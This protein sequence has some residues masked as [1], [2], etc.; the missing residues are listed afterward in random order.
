[1][2]TSINTYCS[3]DSF[4]KKSI[5]KQYTTSYKRQSHNNI[6]NCQN[7]SRSDLLSYD[8]DIHI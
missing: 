2:N 6:P 5:F 1:M 7:V 8:Y 4:L 3:L